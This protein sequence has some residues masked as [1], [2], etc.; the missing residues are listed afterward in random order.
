MS[1]RLA[2]RLSAA[3]RRR[4]VGRETEKQLFQ[5]ALHSDNSAF[6]LL[7]VYGPG[8]VGKTALLRE[9]LSMAQQA[10]ADTI[11]LDARNIEATP[12]AFFSALGAMLGVAAVDDFYAQL[13]QRVKIVLLI[14][15]YEILSS[16]DSWLRDSFLPQIPSNALVVLAGRNP[17]AAAWRVDPGWQ[18]LMRVLSLRNLTPDESRDF[19]N[20]RTVPSSEHDNI[21]EFTHGH[22]LAISLVADLIEQSHDFQLDLAAVPDV[23]RALLSR[24]VEDAPTRN[25][26]LALEACAIVRS[27]T[28]GLLTAMLDLDDAHPLFEWLRGLSFID[29]GRLGLFPHDLVRE[30]VLVDLRWRNP[31]MYATLHSRARVYYH[32]RIHETQAQMQRRVLTDLVFLHRDNAVVRP[33]YEW[34]DNDSIWIDRARQ[35]DTASLLEM[36]RQHEGEESADLAAFWLARQPNATLIVRDHQQQPVGFAMFLGL[37]SAS[38]DEL[39]HDPATLTAWNYLQRYAPLRP[40]EQATF[41]RFWMDREQ[42]QGLSPVQSRIFLACVQH[43][44]TTPGLAYTLFP[45]A[46]PDFYAGV[47]AYADLMRVTDADFMVGGKAYGLFG[48]DWR[49]TPPAAWLDLLAQREVAAN[50][51]TTQQ[52][53]AIT[54]QPTSVQPLLVLSQPEFANAIRDALRHITRLDELQRSPLVRSRLVIDRVGNEASPAKRAS[55]LQTLLK[56]TATLLQSSPK[57][58]KLYRAIYHT[59]LHP[60]ATQELAAEVLDLPFSTYRRHL[61]EGIDSLVDSLWSREVGAG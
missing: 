41:F 10:E 47:F 44:L 36:V 51:N 42:H 39:A 60:A 18:S 46:Q 28:E 16:L 40:N 5:S 24:M 13:T 29:T 52:P 59:Y 27:M 11:Y 25:H 56:E 34:Q 21:V 9:F 33:F 17:P 22:P 50:A 35:E 37:H 1:S 53:Q 6:S 30:A 58:N 2:D 14:D 57:S 26:R 49:V 4:F 20:L 23:V 43:Y 3:R 61:K 32:K 7:F 31:D 48:H 45:C 55:T 19:L 8:G 38:G 15:T 12:D 54:Q